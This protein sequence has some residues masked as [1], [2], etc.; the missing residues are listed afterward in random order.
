[1]SIVL[2]T[3][4]AAA[5]TQTGFIVWKAAAGRLPQAGRHSA[6]AVMCAYLTSPLWWLGMAAAA[7]GWLL[8][9]KA[10]ELGEVGMVQPL[11][12]LGDLLLVGAAVCVFNERLGRREW[13]GLALTLAGAVVLSTEAKVVET[14]SV[15]WPGLGVCLAGAVVFA[16]GALALARGRGRGRAEV[17]LACAVGAA[18]GTGALLTELM[19]AQGGPDVA[20]P[21]SW[22]ALLNPVL[23]A[24]VAA[25]V[26]GLVLL[27]IAF[28]RG[29]AAVIVPVQLAVINA[30]V[31]AGAKGI[32]SEPVTTPKLLGIALI[33]A[34][35]C[36][37]GRLEA[38]QTQ[39]A[40]RTA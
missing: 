7:G 31:V 15:S 20:A 38:T 27:Q 2:I 17:P 12:S 9:V 1:M 34:G 33:V 32:F 10:M 24:V 19:T 29:R 40:L 21:S 5:L 25:N 23:P 37:L 6:R 35:T 22:P 36:L 3:L 26:V 11:M 39:A 8:L 30:L 16:A 14:R 18:F 4:A 28:Q 13:L